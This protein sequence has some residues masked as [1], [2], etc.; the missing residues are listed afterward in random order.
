MRDECPVGT[1]LRWDLR[2]RPGAD[3]RQVL[4]GNSVSVSWACARRLTTEP[5]ADAARVN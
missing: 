1:A 3:A 5:D 2:S 4:D